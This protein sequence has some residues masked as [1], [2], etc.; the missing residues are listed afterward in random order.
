MEMI[1]RKKENFANSRKL[2]FPRVS[3]MQYQFPTRQIFYV[4]ACLSATEN[5]QRTSCTFLFNISFPLKLV[6]NLVIKIN[7]YKPVIPGK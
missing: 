5:T 2:L 3:V 7:T 1:F 4:N 6:C